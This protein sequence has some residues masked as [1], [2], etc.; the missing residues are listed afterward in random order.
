MSQKWFDWYSMDIIVALRQA[1][2]N[3]SMMDKE[4]FLSGITILDLSELNLAGI[5]DFVREMNSLKVIN[6][7]GNK[8]GGAVDGRFFPSSIEEIDLSNNQIIE[9]SFREFDP[10]ALKNL[11]EL[12]LSSNNLTE[13]PEKLYMAIEL[14]TLWLEGNQIVSV[15]KDIK[16]P[17]SLLAIHLDNNQISEISVGRSGL[18]KCRE[19]HLSGNFLKSIPLNLLKGKLTYLDISQNDIE[20]WDFISTAN[21][22]GITVRS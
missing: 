5:P 8:I 4:T 9:F 17:S 7:S 11:N 1:S 13:I 3:V 12:K 10:L 20:D 19:V 2:N 15:G 22:R 21:E 14:Q 16:I 6:L 18:F